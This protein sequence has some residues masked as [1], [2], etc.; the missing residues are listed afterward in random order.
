MQRYRSIIRQ[1]LV[2]ETKNIDWIPR[3][4]QGLNAEMLA[5]KT[6]QSGNGKREHRD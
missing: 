6:R 1:N 3:D 5:G 2:I 4:S